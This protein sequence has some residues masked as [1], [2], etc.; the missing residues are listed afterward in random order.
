MHGRTQV[1]W[2][3]PRETAHLSGFLF[4]GSWVGKH[5]VAVLTGSLSPDHDGLERS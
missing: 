4:S 3:D 2:I 1:L 5:A